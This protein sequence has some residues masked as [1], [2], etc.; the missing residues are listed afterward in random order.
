MSDIITDRH[1][2][3]PKETQELLDYLKK[4]SHVQLPVKLIQQGCPVETGLTHQ[5]FSEPPAPRRTSSKK[6]VSQ[7]ACC[8][9][10]RMLPLPG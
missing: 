3:P 10:L 5:K 6:P 7:P 1:P 4:Y 9:L 2:C 8:R